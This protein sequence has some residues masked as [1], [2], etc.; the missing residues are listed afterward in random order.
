MWY[1]FIK[2]D[3]EDLRKECVPVMLLL[4]ELECYF[5]MG[6]DNL[7]LDLETLSCWTVSG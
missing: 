6:T 5:Y 1:V 4:A 2:V 3:V 7:L